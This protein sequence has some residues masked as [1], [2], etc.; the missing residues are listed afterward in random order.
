MNQFFVWLAIICG[1]CVIAVLSRYIYR[2][3]SIQQTTGEHASK[4]D[5]SM[6][7][8]RD[9]LDLM[10]RSLLDEQVELSEGCIRLKILLDHYDANW[11]QDEVLGVFNEVYQQL[12][13]MPTHQARKQTDKKFLLKLDQQ[14]FAIES[15]YRQAL[16]RAATELLAR[17]A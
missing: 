9:S 2:H 16:R 5:Q 4:I 10:A 7:N 12:A 6:L 1:L 15:K 13:H 3:L 8:L 11:H 14:R 17:I